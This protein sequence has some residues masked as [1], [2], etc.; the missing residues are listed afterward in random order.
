MKKTLFPII[1]LLILIHPT[2][3][4]QTDIADSTFSA[5]DFFIT[6]MVEGF[7]GGF[8]QVL[9]Q[10]QETDRQFNSTPFIYAGISDKVSLQLTN[11]ISWIRRSEILLDGLTIDQKNFTNSTPGFR[12]QFRPLA[13][14]HILAAANW[15]NK[16]ALLNEYV[17]SEFRG[18]T[19]TEQQNRDASIQVDYFSQDG[20]VTLAA[21]QRNWMYFGNSSLP[22][23]E[24]VFETPITFLTPGQT[25]LSFGGTFQQGDFSIF[26]TETLS[27]EIATRSRQSQFNFEALFGLRRNLVLGLS[28]HP[29]V[30][31]ETQN[32]NSDNQFS[33]SL[34]PRVEFLSAKNT[35]HRF[36]FQYDYL[37]N[38]Q[39]PPGENI[40]STPGNS[41]L[42][43]TNFLKRWSFRYGFNRLWNTKPLTTSAFL[44][45][46]NDDFGNRLPRGAIRLSAEILADV[47]RITND[48]QRDNLRTVSQEKNQSIHLQTTASY[49]LFDKLEIGW[50]TELNRRWGKR[51]E[52]ALWNN[53]LFWRNALE[54]SFANYR[55]EE[56]YR[57][58]FGWQQVSNFNRL[59]GPLLYRG[60]FIGTVAVQPVYYS[61][62]WRGENA[63]F[64]DYRLPN[65]R[66]ETWFAE[67]RFRYG[68]LDNLELKAIVDISSPFVSINL[69]DRVLSNL[70][71]AVSW[72]PWN[73]FRLEIEHRIEK[74]DS[75]NFEERENFWN[76]RIISL[77]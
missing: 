62:E 15:N 50:K 45:N 11:Q 68:V 69:R 38:E 47:E 63:R 46:W 27:S 58:R 66:V 48:R 72:Q 71:F 28:V 60:M 64:F 31:R 16:R 53:R 19:E 51:S 35:L 17:F 9:S 36:S 61:R 23:F 57:S 2:L 26:N 21:D 52:V 30:E 34:A 25:Y 42:L 14:L 39:Q 5:P 49:G 4:A 3:W 74:T 12:A 59:F 73:S 56:K 29:D 18:E 33:I 70:Q 7:G 75:P 37:R 41:T 8:E 43:T 65:R 6:R 44:A 77:F 22:F 54:I 40:A 55:F 1:S 20:V 67:G 24:S 13:G 76:L 32:E 10:K